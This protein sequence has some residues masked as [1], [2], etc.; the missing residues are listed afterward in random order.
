M[1]AKILFSIEIEIQNLTIKL[2]N[3][4]SEPFNY[5]L[6]LKNISVNKLK[7]KE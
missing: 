5:F 2:F 1:T 6:T 4:K 3:N 7:H